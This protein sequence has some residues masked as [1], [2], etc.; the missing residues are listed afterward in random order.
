LSL[1]YVAVLVTLDA[2]V[3]DEETSFVQLTV[4]KNWKRGKTQPS[5]LAKPVADM[6]DEISMMQTK[7]SSEH[8]INHRLHPDSH[9]FDAHHMMAGVT[10]DG[11]VDVVEAEVSG[12]RDRPPLSMD[13]SLSLLQTTAALGRA[14]PGA[15]LFTE[16]SEDSVDGAEFSLLQLAVGLVKV[17]ETVAAT[18]LLAE[19]PAAEVPAGG[20]WSQA[21]AATLLKSPADVGK[22]LVPTN[23]TG[24][25]RLDRLLEK[26]TVKPW[27][28]QE[29][30]CFLICLLILECV[31]WKAAQ[32]RPSNIKD[33]RMARSWMR[34]STAAPSKRLSLTLPFR[35]LLNEGKSV[36]LKSAA[37]GVAYL[38]VLSEDAVGNRTVQIS[39]A[40]QP[41]MV[42]M[43][44]G[45]IPRSGSMEDGA[46]VHR[47]STGFTIGALMS[48]GEGSWTLSKNGKTKLQ[49]SSPSPLSLAISTSG[50]EPK[51]VAWV[52]PLSEA[53]EPDYV[54]LSICEVGDPV[55]PMACAI[56]VLV[57]SSSSLQDQMQQ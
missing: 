56:A 21:A 31:V 43:S 25:P 17:R 50:R 15:E 8:R 18:S 28:L 54:D 47:H 34:S 52:K 13:D 51:E 20:S 32:T 22:D 41:T 19:Q 38:A 57:A 10:P 53:K 49:L 36:K 39:D 30:V 11:D 5:V 23:G 33:A 14:A 37:D 24:I 40:A 6:E 48:D 29:W 4:E 12:S 45:P 42:L 55:L 1:L 9:A 7:V 46:A 27:E 35:Q 3:D 2:V 26:M 16:D 44:V